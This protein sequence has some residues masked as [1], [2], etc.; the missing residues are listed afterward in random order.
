[1]ANQNMCVR[2]RLLTVL[3]AVSVLLTAIAAFPI[4]AVAEDAD[5]TFSSGAV[6]LD[7]SYGGKNVL[8]Q[9]GVFS[10]TVNGATN[11]NIIF[12]G[13][14]IDRRYDTDRTSGTR[15]VTGLYAVSR[16]LG[17][18]Y[19]QTCPLLITGN[20][21]AT[22]AF[23]GMNTFYAGTNRCT[24]NNNSYTPVQSGG[25]FAGI[26]V[27]RG[28]T[29]TIA[30]SNGVINAYGGFYVPGDNSENSSYGYNAPTGATQNHLAGGAGIGGGVAGGTTDSASSGYTAGT[31]GTIIINGSTIN[32]YGGHEAAGIGGGVNG[33]ATATS[34]TINGGTVNA[35]GG[36]WA[37]GIGDGDSL[38]NAWTTCYTDHYSVNIK[39]GVVNAVGGVGCPG[40]GSTDQVSNGQ[41][42]VS[43][44]GL[45]IRIEAGTVTARSGYPDKFDPNGSTAY[46]G[47]DA[48]AAIG[49]GNNTN[50]EANSI[51]ISTSTAQ[52]IASGFGHYSV[53]ENGT[54]YDET[55]KVV[56]DRDGYVFLGR[57]PEIVS[58]SPRTFV[59]YEAQR[60]EKVLSSE[61][62]EG[63]YQFLK[64]VTQ[65][66][67]GGEG[68]IYY[69]CA[70]APDGKRFL[71]AGTDGTIEN[72]TELKYNSL[73][74][75][76]AGMDNLL[77]TLWVDEKSVK[78]GE[79]EVPGH[80]RSVAVTLPKPEE[81]GGIYALTV[82]TDALYGYTGSVALPKSG[83]ATITIGAQ[84]AGVISG[85]IAY[86]SKLNL[87]LDSVS[88]GLEDLDIYR[89]G[90]H[91]DG[92]NGLIGER[93]STNL[94]AYV[95][96]IEND[97]TRAYIYAKYAV[98]YGVECK[99]EGIG[100]IENLN[101]FVSSDGFWIVTGE[102]DMTGVVSKTVRLK[103]TDTM[104][105]AGTDNTLNSVIYKL[106]VVK[107]SV[108]TLQLNELNKV[109]D[110]A[111]VSPRIVGITAAETDL[112]TPTEEELESATFTFQ[113]INGDTSTDLGTNA[114]KNVGEY[115]VIAQIRAET[116]VAHTTVRFSI[117]PKTLTVSRIQN[118]L[119]Y[120]SA[121]EYENWRKDDQTE[122]T[123]SDPG[124]LYLNGVVAGD[125]VEVSAE[126]VYYNDIS[127]GYGTTKI[128]LEGVT[129]AGDDVDNYIIDSEQKVFGQINY[130]LDGA[131]FRREDGTNE[132]GTKKNWDKFYPIDSKDPVDKDSADYHSP[133]NAAGVYDSHR[134]YVYA[135]TE[136]HG[137]NESVYAVDIEFGSMYFT[138][139]RSQWNPDSMVYEELQGESRWSGFDGANNRVTIKNRSNTEVSYT[140]NCKIDFLHSGTGDGTTGIK[141]AFY[142][143]NTATATSEIT[144]K[145]QPV[146]AA[147]AGDETK[148]GSPGI[149]NC[150]II[151]SGV[152]QLGDSNYYTVVGNVTVSISRL[153]NG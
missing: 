22:V 137:K 39:G 131:I 44:S 4:P 64:Y 43:T 77:L 60:F 24:L 25:G 14:T 2:C 76:E 80:F 26:Q 29:L 91:N 107:R 117:T 101:A 103:K 132:D 87:K 33:A 141:G 95:V 112:P 126:R 52:V 85:E 69:F 18:T 28:S 127:I 30:Q 144:G 102:L 152:P 96:Y 89:D 108:F 10:V 124:T 142:P 130:T 71:K 46:A 135:R 93:F 114:P 16:S 27:D 17:W 54:S 68:E 139:S 6:L 56:I 1:M 140:A 81:H 151:L 12:E 136:N 53:T 100:E 47:S 48:A 138:F 94:F 106:T 128:T 120:V 23:R 49:A 65:P 13:V 38:Q 79:V 121:A 125:K 115:Y 59:L 72:A 58:A 145:A 143:Q 20:S 99:V 9:N 129:L 148:T 50:M 92:T 42:R 19:A 153:T 105:A 8:I 104:T 34:I 134:E 66:A 83:R 11:V 74:E 40:I 73:E 109:Y 70:D 21:T 75:A 62:V 45:E 118:Q 147:T 123:I 15:T 84:E 5:Y 63:V 3:L 122:H 150:Y 98:D 90:M 111:A 31:P 119:T 41:A 78:I 88:E 32:A 36:R 146:A 61:G 57:A 133:A 149:A 7:S 35:Y 97:D 113:H 86:P 110:G 51:H 67:D 55:P 116:Y 37:A 82:P